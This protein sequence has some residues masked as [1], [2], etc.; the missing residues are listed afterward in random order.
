M[1]VKGGRVVVVR[2]RMQGGDR[3]RGCIGSRRRKRK[4][5]KRQ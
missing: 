1:R 2:G 3:R 4:R 5:R